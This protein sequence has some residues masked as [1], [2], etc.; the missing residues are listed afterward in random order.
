MK[1]TPVAERGAALFEQRGRLNSRARRTLALAD[2][3]TREYH[4]HPAIDLAPKQGHGNGGNDDRGED[5]DGFVAGS[6]FRMFRRRAGL[7]SASHVSG[8]KHER[9]A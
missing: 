2:G 8:G 9:I 7:G 5:Q 6:S 3:T 4:T 1:A